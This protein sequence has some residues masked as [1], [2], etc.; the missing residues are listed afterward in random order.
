MDLKKVEQIL[1][2]Y[3]IENEEM[4]EDVIELAL[5]VVAVTDTIGEVLETIDLLVDD[6]V[7]TQ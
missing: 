4:L 7:E 6:K 2:K 3:D 1:K 5:S